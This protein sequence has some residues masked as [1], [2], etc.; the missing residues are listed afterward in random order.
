MVAWNVRP[1]LLIGAS[2]QCV[3][4]IY[5]HPLRHY[6]GPKLA[7]ATGLYHWYWTLAGRIHRQLH[8]L[9]RQHGEVVRIGPDRLSFIAPEAW[10]DIY[11]PGTTSH[12]ENKKDGRFYAP[13]PNGRRAMISLLD[14]QHH[15]SV[16]R[17]FQPAFSD[18]SLRALEPVIN[19][20]V[21]RLM[22][23]NLRQLA[24][25]DE[26]FDLVH[27]LNC[28]IFD[29]MGDLMLSESFG[30]LEQ[31]AYVEWIETLLVALRYESVGQFLLE[32]AT[33]GKLLSF[34]MPPSARRKREQHVQYTAQR[35]DK[36]QQKSEATKRDIWGFLAAHENAEM[37]DIEDKHA[38][39]SLFMVAG[40]E[41][42]IT[43]LSGLV[44]LLLQHPP[45][46]RRLVAE[47][48]D[49][50]T[51]EDAINM[52]TLQGL[53]Y[54]NACLSEALRLY[55]PVP[56]GNPRVTPA[57]GNV[58]CG[59]AVPG[60]TRVYV[61]TWAACRSA[62]NFGDADSFMPERWLPDSG[63]DSDR[64]EA[65]KPFSYG[66]RNCIGKSMAYHNIRII[67]ARILWNYDLLAAAESDGWMKQ[68]CFPLWDK[69]PLMVRV[70]L[71]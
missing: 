62:S 47:I 40:T 32:Y 43:A 42:T 19:K 1:K 15:A 17:V 54:L 16:R 58:I 64:K 7:A 41:T 48:R 66:P 29:I 12:K 10:K 22:H 51:C 45:C 46:M 35:V 30:M 70:M 11:G 33:L 68:E 6:P 69:K 65:S 63:Y 8:K 18:R 39:A 37:L 2:C 49:S 71:R 27:L 20:H 9:H 52:D 44:F 5:L 13:T 4:N 36:R 38:N 25:A 50:F 14:N 26:P 31:S 21:K 53:S 34:L 3:Y 57:D 67:I 60:H 56:L 55:P 23:T 61:S 24:R 59:H 28:A